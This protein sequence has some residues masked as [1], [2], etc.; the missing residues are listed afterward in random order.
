MGA[1]EW[2]PKPDNKIVMNIAPSL[3]DPAST[4]TEK[5][6]GQKLG[7]SPE[8]A[9]WCSIVLACAGASNNNVMHRGIASEALVHPSTCA[10]SHTLIAGRQ[11]S[12]LDTV[13]PSM[14]N[15]PE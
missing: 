3:V 2:V 15:D 12:G 7:G 10:K 13:M 4:K 11:T 1:N 9:P 8:G 14:I 5:L 6:S